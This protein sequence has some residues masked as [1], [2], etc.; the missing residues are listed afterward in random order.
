MFIKFIFSS[1]YELSSPPTP[2]A[3]LV[4]TLILKPC[5]LSRFFFLEL[6]LLFLLCIVRC[7]CGCAGAVLLLDCVLALATMVLGRLR[8]F[9][10]DRT[11]RIPTPLLACL[12]SFT[13]RHTPANFINH[14]HIQFKLRR[15]NTVNYKG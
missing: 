10:W 4:Y 12:F 14:I 2:S 1:F 7:A 3:S 11:F 5:E 8:L 13:V 15:H 6:I 9:V